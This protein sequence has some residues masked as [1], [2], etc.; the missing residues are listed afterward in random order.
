ME[1]LTNEQLHSVESNASR[2]V[3]RQYISNNQKMSSKSIVVYK[4]SKLRYSFSFLLTINNIIVRRKFL[5]FL[6]SRK[7]NG[8]LVVLFIIL[9]MIIGILVVNL[10]SPKPSMFEFKIDLK[11]LFSIVFFRYDVSTNFPTNNEKFHCL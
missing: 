7:M 6:K 2:S 1:R 4:T 3:G 9:S 8:F 10:T 5:S 11:L